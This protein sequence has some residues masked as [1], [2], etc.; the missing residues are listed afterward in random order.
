M[1]GNGGASGHHRAR[2]SAPHHYFC[3]H[4][5]V[6]AFG[7]G[8]ETPIGKMYGINPGC[9]EEVSDEELERTPI[10][11]VDGRNDRWLSVP[12]FFSLL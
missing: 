10:T 8:S 11:Y 6:P 4:C 7:V 5:G 3:R 1:A 12:G 2:R 9:L